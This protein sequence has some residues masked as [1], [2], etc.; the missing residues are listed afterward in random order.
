MKESSGDF[1]GCWGGIASLQLSLPAVWTGARERGLEPE[2]IVDWMCGAT[3][4]LAGLG[5][6]KGALAEG[7]D[8]DI[9]IWNPDASFVVDAGSL[10][11]RHHL[12]PYA[13]RK[14]YGVVEATFV[15]GEKIGI[16]H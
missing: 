10:F 15:A 5:S 9:A 2:R 4:S 1:F 6:R 12:T 8:A 13:G 3:A 7:F 14:L 16:L 11:H